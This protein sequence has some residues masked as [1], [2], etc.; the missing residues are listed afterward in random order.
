M[1]AK[2][3]KRERES[4]MMTFHNRILLKCI[5]S[6]IGPMSCTSY[7]IIVGFVSTG[8][9]ECCSNAVRVHVLCVFQRVRLAV[10][11]AVTDHSASHAVRATHR[12]HS[13]LLTLVEVNLSRYT[14]HF[15]VPWYIPNTRSHT[16]LL[17]L[18]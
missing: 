11:L 17:L 8:L 5:M 7:Y 15:S 4:Y 14:C 6:L 10:Q 12:R 16:V 18:H 3:G 2:S 1:A 9:N 13:L